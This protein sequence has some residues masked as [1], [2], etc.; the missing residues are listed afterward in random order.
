M[1]RTVLVLFGLI[2]AFSPPLISVSADGGVEYTIILASDGI[3]PENATGLEI[4][5]IAYFYMADS[6]ENLTHN[7]TVDI[8]QNGLFNETDWNSGELSYS[9]E[10][11]ENG[12]KVNSSCNKTA[13]LLFN[14]S[15]G[16]F[17]YKVE[18]SNGSTM[19]G[20]ITVSNHDEHNNSVIADCTGQACMDKDEVKDALGI[21]DEPVDYQKRLLFVLALALGGSGVYILMSSKSKALEDEEE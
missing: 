18:L 13:E 9:C 11:D 1:K 8:N 2:L 16:L 10:T 7:V 19:F 5:N 12:G 21:G 3:R 20:N 17:A 15:T 6:T 4:G 14:T